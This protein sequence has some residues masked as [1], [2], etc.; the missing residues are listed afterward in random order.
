MENQ[1]TI[2]QAKITANEEKLDKLSTKIKNLLKEKQNLEE[3]LERQRLSLQ[4]LGSSK[5]K[6]TEYTEELKEENPEG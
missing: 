2:L 3:K 6:K 1:M 5:G 4:L